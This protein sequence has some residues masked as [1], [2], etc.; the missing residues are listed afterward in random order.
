VDGG[1]ILQR[2]VRALAALFIAA[3]LLA[4]ATGC[5][6]SPGSPTGSPPSP[7]P[8]SGSPPPP[9]PPTG[10]SLSLSGNWS[11]TGTDAQGPET[12]R[13]TL[14]QTG[15]NLTGTAI[16]DPADAT[17]GSCG[18]CHKQKSGTVTGTISGD[19]LTLTMDF[20]KGGSDLTPLCG[21][22]MTATTTDVAA[23]RIASTYTGS[24]TCEGPIT[25]GTLVM[26]R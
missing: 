1:T 19:A 22:T 9:N 24:T 20:P 21:L 11:G 5:G 13:W 23:G 15:G 7:N 14:T 3:L 25:E 8:P 17:D 6:A 26:S 18:S 2:I 10:S 4:M 16:L 12:F